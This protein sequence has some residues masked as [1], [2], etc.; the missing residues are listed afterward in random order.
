MPGQ[1]ELCFL[2]FCVWK[3]EE[4]YFEKI[5]RLFNEFVIYIG[6][7]Y[8]EVYVLLTVL[9]L[10][11]IGFGTIIILFIRIIRWIFRTQFSD[12]IYQCQAS[13]DQE[14]IYFVNRNQKPQSKSSTITSSSFVSKEPSKL[15]IKIFRNSSSESTSLSQRKRVSSIKLCNYPPFKRARVHSNLPKIVE[16]NLAK[17]PG[18]VK[19]EEPELAMQSVIKYNPTPCDISKG[20]VI[21]ELNSCSS[22]QYQTNSPQDLDLLKDQL[23]T[24][25]S[26]M[27]LQSNQANSIQKIKLRTFSVSFRIKYH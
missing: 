14:A 19:A 9:I 11:S 4:T 22:T 16:P 27:S 18:S 2:N 10:S 23:Q 13:T 24:I 17:Y 15:S 21:D 3:R 26:S 8:H 12:H 7:F 5:F 25:S 6:T 1:A 20:E